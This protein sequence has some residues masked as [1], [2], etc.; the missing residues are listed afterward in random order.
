M[1]TARR[2]SRKDWLEA[3]LLAIRQHGLEG[4]YIGGLTRRLGKTTGAFYA[5]FSSTEAF[6]LAV[7]EHWRDAVTATLS[8]RP[9]PAAATGGSRDDFDHRALGLDARVEQCLRRIAAANP[10]IAEICRTVDASRIDYL[11][12]AHALH[13]QR[14]V[15]AARRFARI[16]Y[17]TLVGLQQVQTGLTAEEATNLHDL[18]VAMARALPMV[19]EPRRAC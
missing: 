19:E 11:A 8:G 5:H 6:I 10:Q 16:E 4:L 9:G 14:P 13:G 15:E 17:A 12:N 1:T 2:L 3:G 18:F 7:A